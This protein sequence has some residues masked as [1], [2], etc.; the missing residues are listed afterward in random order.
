MSALW[1]LALSV[2]LKL[3]VTILL[4]MSFV[5]YLRR[6][7]LLAAAN[8]IVAVEFG[9]DRGCKAKLRSEA[10]VECTLLDSTFVTSYLTILNMKMNESR[11]VRHTVILSDSLSAEEFRRLR[12]WLRWKCARSE[13]GGRR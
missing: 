12:V 5:F 9:E 8:S 1:P 2:W 13:E 6:D 7:A 3:G 10:R 4:I 11:T